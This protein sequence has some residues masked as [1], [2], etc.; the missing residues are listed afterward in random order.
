MANSRN[1]D[2]ESNKEVTHLDAFEEARME[3]RKDSNTNGQQKQSDS[4]SSE[5]YAYVL[6]ISASAIVGSC[7]RTYLSR[8]F[9]GDCEDGSVSDFLTSFSSTICVTA[10]GRTLQAGGALF[11]DLPANLLGSFIMG[12]ITP[13]DKKKISR[14]P[15][16]K[17]DHPLQKDDVYYAGLGTGLCGS[18]TTFASWNTQ[19]VVMLVSMVGN[20]KGRDLEWFLLLM[21]F[22]H[23]R[24]RFGL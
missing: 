15:W 3:D 9:G 24:I 12:L 22:S 7:A 6:Y 16:Q 13:K 5:F 20:R 17:K 21:L 19:M 8:L 2:P 10:G 1:K 11:R 14:I 4:D 18:L 23:D